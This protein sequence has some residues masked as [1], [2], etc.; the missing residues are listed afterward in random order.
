MLQFQRAWTHVAQ[1][2]ETPQGGIQTH[3]GESRTTSGTVKQTRGP[4]SQGRL[5]P[6]ASA[7]A[8]STSPRPSS[9]G[10]SIKNKPTH[11]PYWNDDPRTRWLG[12]HNVGYVLIAGRRERVLID[13]GA[14]GNVITPEY[15]GRH[16]LKVGPV[17]E[18]ASNPTSIPVSGIGGHTTALGYIII[19]VQIEGIPS[20]KEDQVA[21]VIEDVSGMGRRVPIILGTPTIHRVCHQMKESELAM[22]PD[23]WQH[24][25]ISYDIAQHVLVN[26]MSPEEKN[27]Y[28]TNT[29]QDPMDLDEPV[30]LDK[31]VSIP[32]FTSKIVPV[33]TKEMFILDHRLNVMVQPPY[34]E[35][36]AKLPV[37]LYVQRV[38]T[39]LHKEMQ[40]LS[41]VLRNGTG[42]PIHLAVGRLVG[43]VVVANA[44]PDAVPSPELEAKLGEETDKPTPLTSE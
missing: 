12:P 5:C 2:P 18:L 24:A 20:Y 6:P 37:G 7:E 30:I 14:R 39:E 9:S 8:A 35:D 34:L 40:G 21:L 28:P 44:V 33:R 26:A 42:K 11:P 22:A 32:T 27:K 10:A 25:V 4:W 31:K 17:C 29:S 3:Q 16:D 15:V 13:S 1:L 19:N 38:Y 43:W 36:H 23:E 41:M